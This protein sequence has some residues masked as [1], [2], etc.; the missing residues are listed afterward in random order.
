VLVYEYAG[1]E[2]VVR[3]GMGK[4][5]NAVGARMLNIVFHKAC[6]SASVVSL[7]LGLAFDSLT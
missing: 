5:S 2:I 1:T 3:R 7:L 4:E 6:F